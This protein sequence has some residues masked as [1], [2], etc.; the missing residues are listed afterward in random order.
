MKLKPRVIVKV[1]GRQSDHSSRWEILQPLQSTRHNHSY[2]ARNLR[3][4]LDD[5]MVKL[6]V[7]R[8]E[9]RLLGNKG[10]VDNVRRRLL[11]QAEMLTVPLNALPEP[12]DLFTCANRQDRFHFADAKSYKTSEPVLVTEA[13][14]GVPLDVLVSEEGPLTESRS[15]RLSL[16][17]C[18][19]VEDLHRHRVLAYEL[20]PEDILVDATDHDR[21]WVL[22]CANYQRTDASGVVHPN[23]LVVPLSDF[24]FAAPEVETGREPLGFRS[25]IYSLGAII[26]YTLTARKARDLRVD[27][28]PMPRLPGVSPSTQRILDRCL[29]PTPKDRFQDTQEVRKALRKAVGT[30][31]EEPSERKTRGAQPTGFLNALR[32]FARRLG[33]CSP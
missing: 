27:G 4:D 22:G 26:L 14:S 21:I 7:C 2:F 23:R 15:L 8:Y 16:K 3:P 32:R 24:S 18:N 17:L 25:D 6:T 11:H 13:Y 12:V 9:K 5:Q 29:A 30:P 10:Y 1:T 31:P 20:R 33:V 28:G 19:L